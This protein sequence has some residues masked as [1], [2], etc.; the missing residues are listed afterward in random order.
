MLGFQA[1]ERT[2]AGGTEPPC[3]TR[4]SRSSFNCSVPWV[5]GVVPL[6]TPHVSPLDPSQDITWQLL[7]HEVPPLSIFLCSFQLK[8]AWAAGG[9]PGPTG[10]V[11]LP[12]QAMC[13]WVCYRTGTDVGG[14]LP[15]PAS[16]G[17]LGGSRE[18]SC[19]SQ[20]PGE[21]AGALS[22]ALG[23]REALHN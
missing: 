6:P 18:S 21:A 10:A 3:F 1:P 16:L 23:R 8:G 2:R 19:T 14:Y 11:S 13:L 17:G 9:F 15:V 4:G 5:V 20:R 22:T 12:G 7:Q